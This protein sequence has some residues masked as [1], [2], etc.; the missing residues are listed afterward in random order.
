MAPE[1]GNTS[2]SELV[3]ERLLALKLTKLFSVRMGIELANC[4]WKLKC[5][6]K[7]YDAVDCNSL[8]TS[9][10]AANATAKSDGFCEHS[11]PVSSQQTHHITDVNHTLRRPQHM[12]TEMALSITSEGISTILI[13]TTDLMSQITFGPN[14]RGRNR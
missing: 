3:M 7:N 14:Q 8:N 6:G 4:E 9:G 11:S 13:I 1:E 10:E 2:N 12:I 5:L